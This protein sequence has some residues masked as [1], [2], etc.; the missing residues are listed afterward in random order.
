MDAL[1]H[2]HKLQIEDLESAARLDIYASLLYYL[3]NPPSA[4]TLGTRGH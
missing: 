2:G 1:N 4:A 3:L